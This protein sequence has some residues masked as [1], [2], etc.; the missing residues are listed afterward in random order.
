MSLSTALEQN[1]SLTVPARDPK[2]VEITRHQVAK[3]KDFAFGLFIEAHHSGKGPVR[4]GAGYQAAGTSFQHGF[5][6]LG[7]N[8][9]MRAGGSG[10]SERAPL[11][12]S[13]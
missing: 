1:P 10:L 9:S 5:I 12:S 6:T 4:P 3:S 13:K 8:R 7:V 11:T 2:S